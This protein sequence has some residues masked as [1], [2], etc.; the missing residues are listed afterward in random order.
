MGQDDERHVVMPPAPE[1][2]FVV[3]HAQLPL[4]FG[5]TGLDRE[6]AFHSPTQKSRAVSPEERCSDKTS[7]PAP[8]PNH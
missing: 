7:T 3:I 2:E 1:T 5:K 8:L 6:A 4:A